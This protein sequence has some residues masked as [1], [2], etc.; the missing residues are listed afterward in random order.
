MFVITDSDNIV[1]DIASEIANLSRGYSF[2]GY[3][4]YHVRDAAGLSI[5]LPL[6][7]GIELSNASPLAVQ[8]I[9]AVDKILNLLHQRRAEALNMAWTGVVSAYDEEIERCDSTL[10]TLSSS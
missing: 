8:Q 7:E 4:I 2:P 6:A 3:R 5:E 9:L 1:Q 10:R